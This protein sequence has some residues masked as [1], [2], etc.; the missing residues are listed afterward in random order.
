MH[1]GWL[2]VWRKIEDNSSWSRGIEYRGLML[3]V[4]QKANWKSGFFQ[5][6]EIMPGQ[7]ATSGDSLANDLKINRLKCVRML[8]KL[9]QDGLIRVENMNNRFTLI[10]VVNW[11]TYQGEEKVN[12]QPM[13]NKRT[14]DEQPMNTIKECKK[15]R[16][17][18]EP[19]QS[20][21][22]SD[23]FDFVS[24]FQEATKS[25]HGNT[26]PDITDELIE[27]GADT[28]DKLVRLDGFKKEDVFSAVLWAT[29]DHFW[30]NQ[31]KS[32]GQLRSKK[33]GADTTKFQNMY[34]GYMKDQPIIETKVCIEPEWE[35]FNKGFDT[36]EYD[37]VE[38]P[39]DNPPK[40]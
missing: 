1:R 8:K 35:E 2:K 22:D 14:T 29:K 36:G 21:I 24:K 16:K 33:K 11:E 7:F 28:I 4:L 3:T 37:P 18:K 25:F 10:T 12:E 27:K 13:N 38:N 32:L 31:I 30:K 39:F 15:E 26:A 5:G 19:K 34:S 20:K 40:L 17:K 6:K 9:S 23:I